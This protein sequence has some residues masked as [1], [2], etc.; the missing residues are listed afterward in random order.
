MRPR[1]PHLELAFVKDVT[2][3]PR[4]LNGA[5]DVASLIN[6]CLEHA[7]LSRADQIAESGRI[8]SRSYNIGTRIADGT[9]ER[10]E[11]CDELALPH[12]RFSAG[13]SGS[14]SSRRPTRPESRGKKVARRGSYKISF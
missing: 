6:A 14:K 11:K 4:G 2:F 1:I 7:T 8:Y 5:R 9:K 12:F 10:A 13:P 3:Q